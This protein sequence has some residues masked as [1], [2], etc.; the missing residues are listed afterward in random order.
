MFGFL[1]CLSD[2]LSAIVNTAGAAVNHGAP[3]T[4]TAPAPATVEPHATAVRS[5][6]GSLRVAYMY[7]MDWIWCNE[8]TSYKE[9]V[10]RVGLE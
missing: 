7:S 4:A 10:I 2:V 8:T 6:R 1:S 5:S 9:E 3:S